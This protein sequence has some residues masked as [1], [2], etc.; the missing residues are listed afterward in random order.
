MTKKDKAVLIDG[1]RKLSADIADLA[2]MLDGGQPSAQEPEP[3][4]EEAPE[5]EKQEEPAKAYTYEEARA[6]LAEKARTGYRAEVKAIL[7]A[8]GL[9]QLSDAKEPELLAAIVAEAE[10]I[11]NA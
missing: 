7:T 8:H 6:I 5:P 3:A 2:A 10:V 1:L 9:S 11:G 4:K